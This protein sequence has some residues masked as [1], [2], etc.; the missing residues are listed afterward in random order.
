MTVAET[1]R[2]KLEAA[3]SPLT[4]DVVDES[5]KHV[6]MLEHDQKA[7][8]TF[9]SHSFLRLST[10]WAESSGTDWFMTYWLRN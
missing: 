3:F 5:H 8:R 10:V 7:K 4:I 6:D 2:K 9:K 1:M